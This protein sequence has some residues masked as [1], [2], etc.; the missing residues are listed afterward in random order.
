MS[1]G[2][3]YTMFIELYLESLGEEMKV[4]VAKGNV[5]SEVQ[6]SEVL[7]LLHFSGY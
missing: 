3:Q 6:F 2:Y 7:L 1:T 5:R 4:K